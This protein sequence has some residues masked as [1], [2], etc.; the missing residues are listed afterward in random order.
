MVDE[1]TFTMQL[2]RYPSIAIA[3]EFQTEGFNPSLK[4][5]LLFFLRGLLLSR[6]I[7]EA[8][9]GKIHELTPLLDSFEPVEGMEKQFSLLST[10]SRVCC[11]AFFKSSFSR[12]SWPTR[13][14]S[15]S[16]RSARVAPRVGSLPNFPRAYCL[17]R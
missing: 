16:T 17:F 3:R 5:L 11:K 9:S 7:I 8:A 6:W 12:A 2:S 1:N 13:R 4:S 10:L 15:F 14:S